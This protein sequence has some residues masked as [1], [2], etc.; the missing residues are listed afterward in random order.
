[1]VFS[2]AQGFPLPPSSLWEAIS[3]KGKIEI[4]LLPESRPVH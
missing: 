2:G 3:R 1:M 4:L